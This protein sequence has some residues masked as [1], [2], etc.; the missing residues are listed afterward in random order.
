MTE[1]KENLHS[2]S[3]RRHH[4]LNL[5]SIKLYINLYIYILQANIK[6]DLVDN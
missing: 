5:I 2:F 1:F 3:D 4:I 6:V